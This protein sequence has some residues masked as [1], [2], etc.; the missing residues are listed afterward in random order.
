MSMTSARPNSITGSQ[1][2]AGGPTGVREVWRF[3]V[4]AAGLV[5]LAWIL[6]QAMDQIPGLA[7]IVRRITAQGTLGM[8]FRF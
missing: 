5:G 4:H 6:Q 7:E 3:L 1:A 2:Q 8:D